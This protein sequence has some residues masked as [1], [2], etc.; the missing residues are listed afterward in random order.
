M[1]RARCV[2]LAL[3]L[4]L[5]AR[6]AAAQRTGECFTTDD[7]GAQALVTRFAESEGLYTLIDGVKPISS[8]TYQ[9][10]RPIADANSAVADSLRRLDALATDLSCA[11]LQFFLHRYAQR[12][13]DR[14]TVEMFVANRDAVRRT[15]VRYA[16]LFASIDVD[17]LTTPDSVVARVDRAERALRWRAFGY[18][19]GFP[20][21][22]VDFFVA[23]GLHEDSTRQFVARDFRR[24]E[25]YRKLPEREGGPAT[26]STFVYAVAKG[27]AE[28]T[29]DQRLRQ[30]AEFI[31]RQY[32][33]GACV[34]RPQVQTTSLCF[35]NGVQRVIAATNRARR[36]TG[37]PPLDS[38]SARL[39][40]DALTQRAARMTVLLGV[41]PENV[42][43]VLSR[44]RGLGGI[45]DRVE[46]ELGYARIR[47]EPARVA[48]LMT[49]REI[50][51]VDLG[52]FADQPW[53]AVVATRA[54]PAAQSRPATTPAE[55]LIEPAAV[56]HLAPEMGTLELLRA[57]PSFDG[58]GVTIAVIDGTPDLLSSH[59]QH[60]LDLNGQRV[61]KFADIIA[62]IDSAA[63]LNPASVPMMPVMTD[64]ARRIVIGGSTYTV[65]HDGA[66]RAGLFDERRLVG[67]MG[68][69][70]NR[71]GN[72]AGSSG[73]FGVLWEPST[74]RVWVD[75][76]QGLRFDDDAPLREYRFAGD[77][78][79]F[80]HDDPATRVRESVGF[81]VQ[82]DSAR[83][84]VTLILGV[85][86]HGTIM[87][88][89]AA[90]HD[91]PGQD[92]VGAAPAARL[93]SIAP[94]EGE[95]GVLEAMIAAVRDPRVDVITD[96]TAAMIKHWRLGH[97]LLSRLPAAQR[98]PMLIGAGNSTGF[99][100][101]T[102]FATP[103]EV[104][105][106]SGY[107]SQRSWL[108][109]YGARVAARD[110]MLA[111]TSFGPAV[112]GGFKPDLIAPSG[113]LGATPAFQEGGRISGLLRLPPGYS[114]F[115]GT[116]VAAPMA[117]GATA[118]LLSAAK[119]TGLSVN[120]HDVYAALRNT[121]RFIEGVDAHRQGAGLLQVIPAWRALQNSMT[122]PVTITVD[123][124][125]RTAES[126]WL[127]TAHRGTGLFERE[128]WQPGQRG[129]RT[130]TLT[131]RGGAAAPLTYRVGWTGNDGTFSAPAHVTL[132]R[133]SAVQL[134]L[135]IAP[136]TMGAHSA[137]LDI[138]DHTNRIVHRMLATII[139]A[140]PVAP[141][142]TGWQRS[143]TIPRPGTQDLFFEVPPGTASFEVR[144]QSPRD[145]LAVFVMSPSR[146]YVTRPSRAQRGEWS[147]TFPAPERGAW[148]VAIRDSDD[149][150]NFDPTR[151]NPLPPTTITLTVMVRQ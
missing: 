138:H 98:K 64:P 23:A 99:N 104:L 107:Q 68:A 126:A 108:V 6:P 144:V 34:R 13:G 5:A 149:S 73:L 88:G 8:G 49:W 39:L 94:A 14:Q 150:F 17:T 109:N 133:D 145:G 15:I 56:A 112:D 136:A 30:A 69:D 63:P 72:P 147:A 142:A 122:T 137:I 45:V 40:A 55:P 4:L 83:A 127:D 111:A 82:I 44:I 115:G 58:R 103:P 11:E 29:A 92:N 106:V 91:F 12:D 89:I 51:I 16:P 90:G 118:Q 9:L 148:E 84:R 21:E 76:D 50:D 93:I 28:T 87:A 41:Q 75:V 52:N 86:D 77:L 33:G 80:G 46:A 3:G 25:T 97:H 70:V 143:I 53:H 62:H 140:E 100:A 121:T 61:R 116:S 139:A 26:I 101:V 27:A 7:T 129:A 2:W 36:W 22:A 123:A 132:P 66:F 79:V 114:I 124:P 20:D 37:A 120:T 113:S 81:A 31:Q 10:Q 42:P 85:D 38:H 59:L 48:E 125:V 65:P 95:H 71:D 24:I 134:E 60:A 19:F 78:G 130:L 117:A 102:S 96:A 18:L 35:E 135:G 32:G 119:Q 47:I 105:A 110:N 146:T 57:H 151:P 1:K 43:V 128:G 74:N 67:R 141:S 131:R 54:P